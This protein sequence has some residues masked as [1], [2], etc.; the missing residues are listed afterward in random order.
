[1]VQ[2]WLTCYSHKNTNKD[3][4]PHQK[5]IQINDVN[6]LTPSI[7]DLLA[8]YLKY[9]YKIGTYTYYVWICTTPI[10]PKKLE[11]CKMYRN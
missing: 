8:S 11:H 7:F 5:N 6:E 2:L 3:K 4:E 10:P 9:I 1:M